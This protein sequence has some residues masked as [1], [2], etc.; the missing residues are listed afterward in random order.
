MPRLDNPHD[1]L[2]DHDPSAPDGPWLRGNLHA[3]TTASDG[4]MPAQEVID[5]YARLGHGFLM[6]SDH[7]IYTGPHEYAALDPRGMVLLAGNEI[8]A[9]GPH[10]LHVGADC[11]VEPHAN[12][13]QCFDAIAQGQGFAIVNHPNWQRRFDHCPIDD[14]HRWRGYVGMEIYNGVIGRHPGSPYATNKWD[15]VLSTGR[16]VWGFAHDDSH[17]AG[18]IGQGWNVVCAG[19][20]MAS[21][22][23]DALRRGRFYTSTGVTIRSVRAT[24]TTVRIETHN[25]RRT[26]ALTRFGRRIA[27]ADAPVLEVPIDRIDGYLRFECWGDG[28]RFA[29]SQPVFVSD[30]PAAIQT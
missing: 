3:H 17:M 25:A 22:I 27:Q 13:Q 15:M 14:L 8:S 10:L 5:A 11:R 2:P 4:Q 23:M 30:M 12:R 18:D 26:V 1:G 29:W 24:A 7:D 16:R 19:D 20:R 9:A 28:E 21:A 6:I